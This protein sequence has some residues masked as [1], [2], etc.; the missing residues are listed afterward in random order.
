RHSE[1]ASRATADRLTRSLHNYVRCVADLI[2]NSLCSLTRKMARQMLQVSGHWENSSPLFRVTHGREM[3]RLVALERSLSSAGRVL[4]GSRGS[5]V[6]R[7][8][9]IL[10]T[11][12]LVA[13][14]A[15]A[16][17]TPADPMWLAGVYD[18]ADH[19]EVVGMIDA[20][21]LMTHTPVASASTPEL[22]GRHSLPPRQMLPPRPRQVPVFVVL[23]PCPSRAPP[24]GP[25]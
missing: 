9:A 4:G 15:L 7:P 12:S 16:S 10:L 6:R 22:S 23:S 8:L 5:H 20:M 1:T 19:D 2:A 11:A 18:A 25:A 13:L 17:A 21:E 24:S 14:N 3:R